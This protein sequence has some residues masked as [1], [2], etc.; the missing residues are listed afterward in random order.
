LSE[1][2]KGGRTK[3]SIGG[4]G[5]AAGRN[6]LV[7]TPHRSPMGSKS[8][9]QSIPVNFYSI[10]RTL[11]RFASHGKKLGPL[12][13]H[14]THLH[15]QNFRQVRD[16]PKSACC[17]S[18]PVSP[19]RRHSSRHRISTFPGQDLRLQ[20]DRVLRHHLCRCATGNRCQGIPNCRRPAWLV[21]RRLGGS[22][23][24]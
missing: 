10:A 22:A 6:W 16:P 18:P 5:N 8:S 14:L 19:P 1:E 3:I 7:N 12:T 9:D 24:P 21:G 17:S 23:A 4:Y 2:K 15:P 13:P 20:L 11:F